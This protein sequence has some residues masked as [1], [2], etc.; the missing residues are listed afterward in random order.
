MQETEPCNHWNQNNN[1]NPN[2]ENLK[3]SEDTKK[4]GVPAS[5]T[6]STSTEGETTMISSVTE[7]TVNNLPEGVTPEPQAADQLH[8]EV[9]NET[10]GEIQ[11]Y[12][13]VS[14]DRGQLLGDQKLFENLKL[15][16]QTDL[17]GDSESTD[18]LTSAV[19]TVK[20]FIQKND[21]SLAATSGVF[22]YYGVLLGLTLNRIKSKFMDIRSHSTVT[23]STEANQIAK[24]TSWEIWILACLGIEKSRYRNL[25]N[26]MQ[27]ARVP[28]AI[29]YSF[30]GTERLLQ[31]N[32]VAKDLNE[33]DNEAVSIGNIINDNDISFDLTENDNYNVSTDQ[34]ASIDFISFKHRMT[35]IAIQYDISTYDEL[36]L[37]YA[38][39]IEA[40]ISK[41]KPFSKSEMREICLIKNA[42]GDT[43]IHLSKILNCDAN[44]D[45]LVQVI[46]DNNLNS[47]KTAQNQFSL[48]LTSLHDISSSRTLTEPEITSM[49]NIRHKIDEIL[50]HANPVASTA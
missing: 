49:Q 46:L 6:T 24:K 14:D 50:A 23:E 5:A 32:R 18:D 3:M 42:G 27:L 36:G 47:L 44:R 29:Q 11:T 43:N 37:D 34:K 38:S 21:L 39:V 48:I 2:K 4:I 22:T 30:I 20:Q 41:P 28:D 45:G 40:I 7:R 25:Q 16:S 17:S 15:L 33:N 35:K 12:L 10:A 26:F 31:L 13:E 1:L 9:V 19:E 8:L